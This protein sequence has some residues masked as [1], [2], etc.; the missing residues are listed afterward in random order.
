MGITFAGQALRDWR[1]LIDKQG[2]L[3]DT[4]KAKWLERAKQ[5]I[6]GSQEAA[7]Q[8]KVKALNDPN[9]ANI[10]DLKAWDHA[11][12]ESVGFGL[13]R[14]LAEQ[15]CGALGADHR[16]FFVDV[17]KLPPALQASAN[18]RVKR[19]CVKE[20]DQAARL[21]V[22]WSSPRNILH[23][24]LDMGS[25][26][27]PARHAAYLSHGLRG[28]FG[29]DPAHRRWDNCLNSLNG[30]GLGLMRLE[31]L[32]VQTFLS[33]PWHGDGNF[34][35]LLDAAEEWVKSSTPEDPVFVETYPRIVQH[36][37]GG[38]PPHNYGT[39]E[40]KAEVWRSIPDQ[41]QRFVYGVNT[42]M[43]RWFQLVKRHQSMKQ[44]WALVAAVC[45]YCCV[46]KGYFSTLAETPYHQH[47]ANDH[48]PEAQRVVHAAPPQ[49]QHRPRSVKFSNAELEKIRSDCANGFHLAATILCMEET[50]AVM[51]GVA[52]VA[53][54]LMQAHS[55]AITRMKT[56]KGSMELRC[57]L[58][59]GRGSGH[60]K[61]IW[62]A[63]SSVD[64][65]LDMGLVSYSG[66]V[67]T[68]FS[69]D[70]AG[71]VAASLVEFCREMLASE[72]SFLRNY[73][74]DLP[75]VFVGLVSP[76][77]QQVENT[78]RF[79]WQAFQAVTACEARG[80]TDPWLRD[81]CR[82]LLWPLNTWCREVCI[83]VGEMGGAGI[84][85]D[86]RSEVLAYSMGQG[87]TKANEDLFN[88]CRKLMKS[89]PAGK[90]SL[91]SIWH[92]SVRSP[93]VAENDM[94][95][96]KQTVAD[97]A[98]AR[99]LFSAGNLPKSMFHSKSSQYSLGEELLQQYSAKVTWP[100]PSTERFLMRPQ[101]LYS[102]MQCSDHP[103]Q[104][105]RLWQC[106]LA[107]VG[108]L[109]FERDDSAGQAQL[110]EYIV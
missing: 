84:P 11:W 12:A 108:Q 91:A 37:T 103:E 40:H 32:L 21:E 29:F 90:M 54:P 49:G 92:A 39:D 52:A 24:W 34:G 10:H 27:W 30:S 73:A 4:G 107:P 43:N 101:A 83:A 87:T 67:H 76:D 53:D 72:I 45:M 95:L 46:S 96:P 6:H 31:I 86:V 63:L 19:A 79:V 18:G 33:G 35:K 105:K 77:P 28:S 58:A 69:P 62:G 25:I 85:S 20:P 7:K 38:K 3:T 48:D 75:N 50:R 57:E 102:L 42:K 61:S 59:C 36:L 5:F 82:N 14:F 93:L 1:G 68:S 99:A 56:R 94:R 110:C 64:V 44:Y 16:R 47:T 98:C 23:T 71:R 81:F 55:L 13:Q 26:G 106:K 8:R 80:H 78:A 66:E 15:R 104:L 22:L 100:S 41:V 17:G 74:E 60:L 88:R 51:T 2:V 70:C 109:I 97:T 9:L 65:L 89:S